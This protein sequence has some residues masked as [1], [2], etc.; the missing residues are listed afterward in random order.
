MFRAHQ[1]VGV[2]VNEADRAVDDSDARAREGRD[3]HTV[4]R[5]RHTDEIKAVEVER[6]A[7]GGCDLDAVLP[8]FA[9]DV[10][11]EVV[12]TVGTSLR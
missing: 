5:A 7:A 11:R 3:G 6:H 10:A 12:R 1:A 4:E 8:G 2:D 9:G